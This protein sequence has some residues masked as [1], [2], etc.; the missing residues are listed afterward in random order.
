MRVFMTFV[1]FLESIGN[2][3]D[4]SLSKIEG[5]RAKNE[6]IREIVV[7][8]SIKVNELRHRKEKLTLLVEVS[9]SLRYIVFD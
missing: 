5:A 9:E 6:V 2:L 8:G 1:T 4:L 7:Q 3:A